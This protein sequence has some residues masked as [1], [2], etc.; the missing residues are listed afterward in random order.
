MGVFCELVVC[1]SLVD[2]VVEDVLIDCFLN[3]VVF[4]IVGDL[5]CFDFVK[6]SDWLCVL[7]IEIVLSF[8]NEFYVEWMVCLVYK[9]CY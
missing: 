5:D 1:L 7:D 3:C 2:Y 8:D 9:I 6:I 4:C